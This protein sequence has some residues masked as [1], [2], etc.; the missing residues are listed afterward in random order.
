MRHYK[1]RV[2]Y[3]EEVEIMKPVCDSCSSVTD[4]TH[5]CHSMAV[6]LGLAARLEVS[7]AEAHT[8]LLH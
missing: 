7:N 5:E 8:V 3:T 2:T 1:H 4:K 6:K